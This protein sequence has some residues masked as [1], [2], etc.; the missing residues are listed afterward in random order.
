[1]HARIVFVFQEALFT[2]TF[3]ILTTT[4][5]RSQLRSKC[6]TYERI[7]KMRCAGPQAKPFGAMSLWPTKPAWPSQECSI[8]MASKVCLSSFFEQQREQA[9][10][11]L[12]LAVAEHKRSWPGELHDTRPVQQYQPEHTRLAIADIFSFD[13]QR[14]NT[15]SIRD[16]LR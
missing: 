4:C 6:R 2:Q 14:L 10:I 12:Y 11:A 16:T 1:M 5:C 8:H 9:L 13:N 3:L 7:A 15:L